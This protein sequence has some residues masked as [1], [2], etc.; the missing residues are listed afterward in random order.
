MNAPPFLKHH[1][2]HVDAQLDGMLRRH[3]AGMPDRLWQA[4]R[5]SLLAGGKRIRPILLLETF[6]ACGG[7]PLDHAMPA[8]ISLECIHTYS[9]I[10]DDLP[11]MDDDELRRGQPT[12]HRRFDEATALLASDALLTLGLQLLTEADWPA[13][14]RLQLCQRLCLAAGGQGMVGGQLLDMEANARNITN[15]CEIERIHIHKTG[16]L[17]RYACE[18]GAWIAGATP[19]QRAHCI[20]YGQAI[21]LLF[22]VVDDILDAT[23]SSATLGKSAGKDAAQDKATYV[24]L[25]GLR[26][27]RELADELCAKAQNACAQL[28]AEADRM[29]QLARYIRQRDH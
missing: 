20:R 29:L 10:Q 16:A 17:I 21:G 13:E 7:D 19:T 1:A 2:Q 14:V 15:E 9:L 3:R 28:G 4:M 18:A 11:C 12:C 8:A 25:L 24:S 27:A 22:Q 23:Q 5:Y 26:A 6:R